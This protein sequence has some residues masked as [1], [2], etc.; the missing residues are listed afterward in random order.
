MPV[1]F[2]NFKWITF[3]EIWNNNNIK[4]KVANFRFGY[5][6]ITTRYLIFY[7]R[8]MKNIFESYWKRA[9]AL[10]MKE[11]NTLKRYICNHHQKA[12]TK[13][14]LTK[15]ILSNY[16]YL[17]LNCRIH[18]TNALSKVRSSAAATPVKSWQGYN[19]T[20]VGVRWSR[21]SMVRF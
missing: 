14:E 3:C 17:S 7:N 5:T 1:V 20:R 4:C 8:D 6:I 15:S 9:A 11:P 18:F 10:L 19:D 21:R 12:A 2:F 13:L 16:Y